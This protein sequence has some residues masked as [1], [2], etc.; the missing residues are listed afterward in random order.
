MSTSNPPAIAWSILCL[1]LCG[2]GSA[3]AAEKTPAN[4][5]EESGQF[6]ITGYEQLVSPYLD[7]DA[8]Q[9]QQSAAILAQNRAWLREHGAEISGWSK[10]KIYRF[11]YDA[12]WRAINAAKLPGLLRAQRLMREAVAKCARADQQ[13]IRKLERGIYFIILALKGPRKGE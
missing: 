9:Q 10:I 5:C 3:R 1:I 8:A 13:R 4:L 12:R 7:R 2:A 11:E 6:N